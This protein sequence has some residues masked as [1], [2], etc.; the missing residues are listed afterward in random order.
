MLQ[1]LVVLAIV[2]W[3]GGWAYYQAQQMDKEYKEL[4][5]NK[6][7]TKAEAARKA[8]LHTYTHFF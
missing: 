1:L 2:L 8:Y 3:Y 4:L 7:K 6:D 5:K